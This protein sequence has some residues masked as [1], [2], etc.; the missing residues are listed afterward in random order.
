MTNIVRYSSF[1]YVGLS[2]PENW[3]NDPILTHFF[4]KMGWF[5]HQQRVIVRGFQLLPDLGSCCKELDRNIVLDVQQ[6]VMENCHSKL[7]RCMNRVR[8]RLSEDVERKR[9]GMEVQCQVYCSNGDIAY[10]SS[11]R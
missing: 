11:K 6:V 3:G 10:M 5:N 9:I 8:G 1:Q 7:S 4:S 2:Y